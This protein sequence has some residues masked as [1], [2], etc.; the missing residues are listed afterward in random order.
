MRLSR[1]VLFWVVVIA[2]LVFLEVAEVTHLFHLG[3]TQVLGNL[4]SFVFALVLITVLALVGAVFVGIFV[5]HRILSPRGFTPFEE[6]ML[7]MRGEV[8]TLVEE[9]KE[10]KTRLAAL[11]PSPTQA[12]EA[13]DPDPRGRP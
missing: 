9:M 10:V 4:L 2:V 7:K 11:P 3:Y 5:A 12:G 6:E 13:G 8:Q 1:T